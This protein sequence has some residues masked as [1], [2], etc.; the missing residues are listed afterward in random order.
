MVLAGGVIGVL[1]TAQLSRFWVPVRI[2]DEN[3]AHC[4]V[5]SKTHEAMHRAVNYGVK[6][7]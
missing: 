5:A 4:L 3:P 1:E 6:R 7:H 2:F